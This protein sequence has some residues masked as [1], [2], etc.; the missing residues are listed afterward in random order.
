MLKDKND[1]LVGKRCLIIGSGKV[2]RS[3]AEKLL[4]FGAIPITFSDMSGHVYEPDGITSGKLKVIQKIKS[5]RGNL[6]GRYIISS[7]T[8]EFNNPTNIL[9]IPCDLCFPCGAMY[10]INDIDVGTLADN[11]CIGIIE[12]GHSTVTAE[13]RTCLKKRSML[14]GPHTMTLTGNAILQSLS[15]GS[16]SSKLSSLS[17]QSLDTLLA[18]H[19]GA[20]YKDVKRT[21]S[22]FNVRGDLFAGANIMGFL[23][24]A[25]IM[26]THGAV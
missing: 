13:A 25:N 8:A 22:E 11:G 15:G 10:D 9:D 7:T 21:A 19:A 26:V 3:V 5:E 17:E 24:V 12:G 16:N 6:L 4:D 20:I 1:T 14:Y 2:A 23:R 18:D